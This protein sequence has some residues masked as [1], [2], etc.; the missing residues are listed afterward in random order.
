MLSND[1]TVTVANR[2]AASYIKSAKPVLVDVLQGESGVFLF[3]LQFGKT[4][5]LVFLFNLSQQSRLVLGST[6]VTF[7][8]LRG[9]LVEFISD[10]NNLR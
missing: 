1:F 4:F 8:K 3:Y 9:W 2:G 7:N 10:V 5:P 6:G